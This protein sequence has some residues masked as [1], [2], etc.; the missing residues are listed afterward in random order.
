MCL[1][2]NEKTDAVKKDDASSAEIYKVYIYNISVLAYVFFI[3]VYFLKFSSSFYLRWGTICWRKTKKM[4][5][6]IKKVSKFSK[7]LI[8]N[9]IQSEYEWVQL[10]C[11]LLF[12]TFSVEIPVV[13]LNSDTSSV[14]S[15]STLREHSTFVPDDSQLSLSV[16]NGKRLIFLYLQYNNL[17]TFVLSISNY[18]MNIWSTQK[19][20]ARKLMKVKVC[21]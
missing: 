5:L 12:A 7:S 21:F 11:E 1:A 8:Q 6:Q 16:I 14:C 2:L 9:M 17:A 20:T 13:T 15:L 19:V 4:K 18:N 3:N 10:K